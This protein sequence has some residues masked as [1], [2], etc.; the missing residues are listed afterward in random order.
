LPKSVVFS[1]TCTKGF[2]IVVLLLKNKSETGLGEDS[3]C[4]A[5]I[6]L[7]RWDG[8]SIDRPLQ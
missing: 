8:V 7:R 2:A 6:S 3:S 4:P 1:S 5:V